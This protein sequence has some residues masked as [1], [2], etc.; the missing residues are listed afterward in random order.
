MTMGKEKFETQKSP[1][2]YEILVPKKEEFETTLG[3]VINREKQSLASLLKK[4]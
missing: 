4:D 3:E 1:N 2:D